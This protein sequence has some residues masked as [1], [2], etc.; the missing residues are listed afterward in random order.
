[1][2]GYAGRVLG[3]GAFA[4]WRLHEACDRSDGPRADRHRDRRP[5]AAP[6]VTAWI[7]YTSS[8]AVS[9]KISKDYGA[10]DQT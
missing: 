6:G 10:G 1:M 2:Y 9:N 5:D 8:S 4:Y 3:G 7:I